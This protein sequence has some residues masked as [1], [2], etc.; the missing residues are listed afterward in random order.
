[1]R[2]SSAPRRAYQDSRLVGWFCDQTASH[3]GD[4][5]FI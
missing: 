3:V 4:V 5:E 1:M 2:L